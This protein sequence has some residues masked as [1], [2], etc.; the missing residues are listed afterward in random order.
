[1]TRHVEVLIGGAG[2]AGVAT[3]LALRAAGHDVAIVERGESVGGTWRDNRY[4]GVACDV[5]AHVYSLRTHPNPSWSR[6]YAPGEEIRT[7]LEDV[8]AR[9]G[10]DRV[11]RFGTALTGAAWD[12][13]EDCWRITL[14]GAEQLTAEVLVMAT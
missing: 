8:V 11:I 2:F 4:P 12:G 3:A 13:D 14:S 1:M 7:Y 10:I 9:E 6:E 5:P